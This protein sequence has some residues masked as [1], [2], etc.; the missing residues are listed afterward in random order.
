[1]PISPITFK[2]DAV[3]NNNVQTSQTNAAKEK[4]K[5][6]NI[7]EK[8][9][10]KELGLNEPP[11]IA[12]GLLSAAVWFGIGALMDKGISKMWKGYN[13]NAKTSMW[14]NGVFGLVMGTVD[15]FRA[16]KSNQ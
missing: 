8:K 14:M 10:F 15:F 9:F 16:R 1:M 7:P 13:Y 2:A 3:K 12:I 4:P 6:K 11:P 5:N